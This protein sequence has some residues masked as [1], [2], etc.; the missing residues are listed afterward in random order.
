MKRKNF[1][2]ILLAALPILIA[3]IVF[4][5]LPTEVAVHFGLNGEA[6]RF[7]SKYEL[8]LLPFIFL[9]VVLTLLF[10]KLTMTNTHQK[11]NPRVITITL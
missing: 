3:F 10:T 2:C 4:P 9:F 7:G 1:T 6:D 5:F 8:L 11:Q